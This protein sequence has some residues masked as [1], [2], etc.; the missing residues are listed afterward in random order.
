MIKFAQAKNVGAV[1]THT[2][3][4]KYIC[5]NNNVAKI[6]TFMCVVCQIARVVMCN[7]LKIIKNYNNK[8]CELE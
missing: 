1:H 5:L 2:H 4:H 8:Y 3:T 6:A 7:I